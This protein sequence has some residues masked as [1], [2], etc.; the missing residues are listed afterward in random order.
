MR[1]ITEVLIS[2]FGL[3]GGVYAGSRIDA[4]YIVKGGGIENIRITNDPEISAFPSLVWNGSG[5]GLAWEDCRDGHYEIY[6]TRL[7]SEGVK[8]GGDIR[9][10]DTPWDSPGPSLV[11]NGSGYGVSWEDYRHESTEIYFARLNEE[12]IK[13]GDDIRVTNAPGMSW[14][15]CLVWTGTEYGIAWQDYRDEN[16]EIYFARLNSEG[17]KI[18]D[19]VRVTNNPENSWPPCLVWTGSEYG[20]AW[21]DERD[22]SSEIYFVRLSSEGEKLGED[23]RVTND[24]AYSY[25]PSLVWTGT[26]YGLIWE[27]YRDGTLE[28]YF[29]RLN[30]EGVKLGEDVRVTENP[31]YSYAPSL[32]WTGSEYGLVWQDERDYGYLYHQIY[33]RN[34]L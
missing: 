25:S 29:A 7:D 31:A 5:Y 27:D 24:P 4:R 20:I 13:I 12:G 23:I 32:V 30:S 16:A 26:E 18:G 6:F 11:W 10:S 14:W 1:G 19:D 28:I 17:E 34:Y 22:G 15:S 3:F 33:F 21:E 2:L 9:V 8:I